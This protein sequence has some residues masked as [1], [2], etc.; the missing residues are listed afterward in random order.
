MTGP[1]ATIAPMRRLGATGLVSDVTWITQPFGSSSIRG[2]RR[3]SSWPRW[4]AK[5]SSTT[6]APWA[7]AAATSPARRSADMVAPVGF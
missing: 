4:R 3:V 1:R 7:P 2:E 6:N 5:S